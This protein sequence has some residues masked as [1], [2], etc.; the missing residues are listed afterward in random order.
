MT[1][2]GLAGLILVWLIFSVNTFGGQN[3]LTV[4]L[5]CQKAQYWCW[6]ACGEMIMSY[7]HHPVTQCEQ[8]C[9]RFGTSP[10]CQCTCE[11]CVINDCDNSGWPEFSKYGF[12]CSTTCDS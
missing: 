11:Q 2:N 7:Y 6:A 1:I 8:A 12:H 5:I 4:P 3:P 9:K 10:C